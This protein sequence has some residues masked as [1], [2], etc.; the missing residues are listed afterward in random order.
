MKILFVDDEQ[1][2]LDGIKRTLRNKRHDWEMTFES[3][4]I[5][6]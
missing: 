3:D 4:P 1:K 5:W 2:V 6:R